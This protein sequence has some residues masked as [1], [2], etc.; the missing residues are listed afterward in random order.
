MDVQ[1]CPICRGE[2]E[3]RTEKFEDS[4]TVNCTQCGKFRTSRTAITVLGA[5]QD[6]QRRHNYLAEAKQFAK[7]GQPPFICNI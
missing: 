6:P 5:T 3:V 2:A 7:S 1:S 4:R